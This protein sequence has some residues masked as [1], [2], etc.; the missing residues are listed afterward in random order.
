MHC[1]CTWRNFIRTRNIIFLA[2]GKKSNINSVSSSLGTILL[3]QSLFLQ[4]FRVFCENLLFPDLSSVRQ[5][6]L[7]PVGVDQLLLENKIIGKQI[8]MGV[9]FSVWHPAKIWPNNRLGKKKIWKGIKKMGEM[10]IF[11]PIGKHYAYFFPNWLKIYKITQK[12]AENFSP[13][14]R[15]PSLY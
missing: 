4:D 13:A 1:T 9:Y 11:P 7:N 5:H 12:K 10:H 6:L 15:T 14:A 8:N 2:N 3:V